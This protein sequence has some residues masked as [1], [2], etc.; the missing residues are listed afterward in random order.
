MN[1]EKCRSLIWL[2]TEDEVIIHNSSMP[3]RESRLAG[4]S[5]LKML[6]EPS[7]IYQSSPHLAP[8]PRFCN[9][10]MSS[11]SFFFTVQTDI[12]V[13]TNIPFMVT[14][15]V[16]GKISLSMSLLLN[17][18]RRSS[19]GLGVSGERVVSPD[20]CFLLMYGVEGWRFFFW[21][22]NPIPVPSNGLNIFLLSA[23]PAA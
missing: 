6:Y 13:Y 19:W 21:K 18:R 12:L 3:P 7:S 20:G 8:G 5:F 9:L 22:R 11:S 1:I 10:P 15:P 2:I 23:V 16:T 14:G 17:R 4:E